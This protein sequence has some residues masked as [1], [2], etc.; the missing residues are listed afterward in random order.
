MGIL[1]EEK[2]RFDKTRE[3]HGSY[4]MTHGSFTWDSEFPRISCTLTFGCDSHVS[5]GEGHIGSCN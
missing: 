4:N 2:W 1:N 5:I 3:S